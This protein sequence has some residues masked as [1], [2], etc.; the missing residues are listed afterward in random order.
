MNVTEPFQCRITEEE[1]LYIAKAKEKAGIKT[2]REFVTE[3]ACLIRDN[4]AYQAIR[5]HIIRLR[6]K[7]MK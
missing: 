1:N 6:C 5:P 4:E 3:Y 2:A 7:G